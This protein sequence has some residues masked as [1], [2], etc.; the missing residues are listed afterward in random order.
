MGKTNSSLLPWPFFFFGCSRHSLRP[1][2]GSRSG[3]ELCPC[4]GSAVL[5]TVASRMT[6][7]Q[8]ALRPECSG[9][10]MELCPCRLCGSLR[11]L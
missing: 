7:A 11:C 9:F 8:K 6:P 4:C 5:T 2:Q 10:L 1:S 3:I